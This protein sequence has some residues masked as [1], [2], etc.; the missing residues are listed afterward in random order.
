MTVTKTSRGHATAEGDEGV[1]KSRTK[2]RYNPYNAA[3]SEEMSFEQ[4]RAVKR[5]ERYAF[6]SVTLETSRWNCEQEQCNR[7]QRC[8]HIATQTVCLRTHPTP[9]EYLVRRV[10]PYYTFGQRSSCRCVR[11]LDQGPR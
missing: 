7:A 9:A 1:S 4:W 3:Q 2:H 8:K 11:L 6:F 10:Q 5:Q